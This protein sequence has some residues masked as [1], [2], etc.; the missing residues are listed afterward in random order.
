MGMLVR[1]LG[2]D[3]TWYQVGSWAFMSGAILNA[4]RFM[5]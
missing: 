4:A 2:L 3:L 5:L 1:G